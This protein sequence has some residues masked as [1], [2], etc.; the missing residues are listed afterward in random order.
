MLVYIIFVNLEL[1]SFIGSS[2]IFQYYWNTYKISI[3]LD[4][5]IMSS[6]FFLYYTVLYW[7]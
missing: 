5:Q 4:L 6:T 3:K 7:Y 1:K 2:S